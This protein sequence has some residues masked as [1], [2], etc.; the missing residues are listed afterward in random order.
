MVV[1]ALTALFADAAGEGLG[2]LGPVFGSELQ[3]NSRQQFI[4]VFRPGCNRHVAPVAQLEEALVT[5][6]FRLA[7]DL[8]YA[9]PG[10]FSVGL[11]QVEQ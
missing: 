5:L 3:H 10:R 6:Y 8:G 1:P 2:H 11:D 4:F 9:V 7:E